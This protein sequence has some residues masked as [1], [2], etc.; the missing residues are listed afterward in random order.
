MSG[1]K[2]IIE[3]EKS[4]I[5]QM[6]R[7]QLLISV[8]VLSVLLLTIHLAGDIVLGIE[9]GGPL[10]LIVL[11]ILTV[12]L[13]GTLVLS[14]KR[15]GYIITLLGGL[16]G[17]LMPVIHMKGNGISSRVIESSGSF[18]FVWTLLTLGVTSLFAVTLSV[19]GLWKLATKSKAP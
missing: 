13:Y 6:K 2:K 17:L 11:P 4:N 7:D 14:G 12:W 18:I 16:L 8:S 1:R 5:Q 3:I 15:S 10:N 9:P 19:I